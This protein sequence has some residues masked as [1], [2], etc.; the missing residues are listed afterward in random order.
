MAALI[1]TLDS[2]TPRQVG[3][4]GLVENAWSNDLQERIVQLSFQLVRTNSN[5]QIVELIKVFRSI[6]DDIFYINNYNNSI[7]IESRK[8][9]SI[10]YRMIA[11]T[12]DIIDGKGE[13]YLTYILIYNL[14]DYSEELALDMI[15][16]LVL[17]ENDVLTVDS[18]VFEED[19]KQPYGSWKDIKYLCNQ[20]KDSD[21]NITKE[22]IVKHCIRL[23][24]NQLSCDFSSEKPSLLAKW[25]PREGSVKFGWLFTL[26]AQDFYS[27]FIKTANNDKEKLKR[28]IKKCHMEYRRI[29]AALNKKLD[30]TQ[31]KQ[32]G[33][34]WANIKFNNVTSITLTKQRKAFLNLNKKG[35]QRSELEDRIE[36]AANFNKFIE[37]VDN[38]EV[39]AKGQRVGLVDFCKNAY[40]LRPGVNDNEIKLLNAQWDNNSLQNGKLDKFIAMVDVSGSMSGDPMDAAI[41][42]GIRV[43]EKS[44]LGK[45]VLTF[46]E[47]PTWVNLD[48]DLGFVQMVHK[49]K[50]ADWGM[51]TN[52]FAALQ[53]ILDGIVASKLSAEETEG[54]VLAI[55]S[56]MQMDAADQ[57]NKQT[58]YENISKLYAET[59]VKVCGKP[60]SPPHILFWNLRSTTGTPNLSSQH[61]TSMLSGFSPSLLNVFCEEGI[62]GLQ[63]YTP[64]STLLKT[65][66]NKR[67]EVLDKYIQDFI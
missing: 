14:Y 36:C 31:I 22:R 6:L 67:Y 43:A 33:K 30:T 35:E 20:C 54:M 34:E 65:L 46:S 42:L 41:A 19:R 12:R 28:A 55:F 44:A 23:I 10:I 62:E 13:Y 2:M 60:Y 7:S 52:F 21:G 4:N 56:D 29:V 17:S 24:N 57:S 16:R 50:H 9:L 5:H 45:R 40:R 27:Y 38:G 51:N 66:A 61:N 37:K 59:G 32:C 15:N 58:L 49:V 11:N 8:Y 39:V 53:M 18:I 3:E 26:L 63:Q 47:K 48:G 64:W 1:E 25:I